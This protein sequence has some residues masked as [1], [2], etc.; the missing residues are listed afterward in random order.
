MRCSIVST[1]Q[2]Y[3]CGWEGGDLHISHDA[4]MQVFSTADGKWRVTP[5]T[6]E[7]FSW[8][9]PCGW[10][11]CGITPNLIQQ[12]SSVVSKLH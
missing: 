11:S 12:I 4:L 6:S 3:Y 10:V 5:V 2:E 9:S 1:I 8:F 7:G